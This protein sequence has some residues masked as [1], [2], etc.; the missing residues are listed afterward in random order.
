M[1]MMTM[2]MMVM[3]TMTMLLVMMTTTTTMMM[4]RFDNENLRSKIAL[5]CLLTTNTNTAITIRLGW[6]TY[7]WLEVWMGG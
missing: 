7:E 1:M 6:R 2:M 5:Y 3:M 4:M